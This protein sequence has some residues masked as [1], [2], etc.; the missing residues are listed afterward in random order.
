MKHNQPLSAKLNS[1]NLFIDFRLVCHD[2]F[3]SDLHDFII[4]KNN[5]LQSNMI[6]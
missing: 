1:D 6:F 4:K 3:C 5:T 2:K